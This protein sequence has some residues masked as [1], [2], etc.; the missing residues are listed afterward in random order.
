MTRSLCVSYLSFDL[1]S[2]LR[3]PSLWPRASL[4]FNVA[5]IF[6]A[7]GVFEERVF[8]IFFLLCVCAF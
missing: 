3:I 5:F 2:E 1:T 6:A 7:A 8:N 4:S